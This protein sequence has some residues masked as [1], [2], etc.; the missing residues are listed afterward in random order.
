MENLMRKP[1]KGPYAE[2]NHGECKRHDP[3]GEKEGGGCT[4]K[5]DTQ[6]FNKRGWGKKKKSGSSGRM[7]TYRYLG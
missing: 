2:K 1:R 3:W 4:E 6:L 5:P 7:R